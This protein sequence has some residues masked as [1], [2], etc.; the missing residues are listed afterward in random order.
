MNNLPLFNILCQRSSFFLSMSFPTIGSC[1]DELE[2]NKALC[3]HHNVRIAGVIINKVLPSKYEQTKKYMSLA[4]KQH[5]DNVPLL[6]C[7]PDK[8]YLGCPALS[9]LEKLFDVKLLSGNEEMRYRHYTVQDI[10]LVTTSHQHFFK[11]LRNYP[12]RSLYV[13][14]TTQTEIILSFIEYAH[15]CHENSIKFE[16]ALVICGREKKYELSN[17]VYKAIESSPIN[18]PILQCSVTTHQAMEK[19]HK[20]TPKLNIDDKGRTLSA[21]EHYEQF[22][23]FDLLL[24]R[25]GNPLESQR[26]AGGGGSGG[27]NSSL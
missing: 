11:N 20:M 19:I 25:T 26:A 24:E 16:S 22:I 10:N 18:I 15:Y 8:P 23:D 7:I 13:C 27:V 1:F 12:T 5:W 2:L 17:E 14:H 9:D 6:G 3:D 21:M 4:L